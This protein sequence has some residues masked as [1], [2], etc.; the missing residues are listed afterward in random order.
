MAYARIAAARVAS[1]TV[2]GNTATLAALTSFA[3]MVSGVGGTVTFFGVGSGS[4]GA[5]ELDFFGAVTPNIAVVAGVTPQ[6]NTSTVITQ[7]VDGMTNAAATAFL[8]LFFDN[9]N[10][11]NIGD[12]T[13]LRGSSAAGNLYLSL[14]TSTPAETG[15]QGTNEIGYS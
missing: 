8:N 13:G 12:A 7:A 11:S 3:A 4:S 15:N 5:T 14:H 1:F 10:W 2:S 6:L 9:T